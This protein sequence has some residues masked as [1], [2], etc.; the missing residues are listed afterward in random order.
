MLMLKEIVNLERGVI[1]ITGNA[2]K[3]ARIFLN[4]WLSKGK[5]FLAE[6]LPF[7][8][9]YPESV[10]IGNIDETIKFDGYFLYSLLSKPKTERKK[11]YSFI[12]NHDDRVILIYEPKYF[13]D[14]VFKYAIKDVIDYLVAYKRETMGMDR[15]DVYRIEDGKV[16]EKKTYVRRFLEK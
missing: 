1:L 9:G 8:V 2:K 11:Y 7:E 15:V 13:K 14:S 10:F 5:L 12:S 3:L 16:V 6:Y 4:A